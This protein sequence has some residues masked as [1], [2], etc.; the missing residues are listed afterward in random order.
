[1]AQSGGSSPL[2][3]YG[4]GEVVGNTQVPQ[5]LMGSVGVAVTEP[6]GISPLNPASYVSLRKATFETGFAGHFTELSTDGA[7]QDRNDVRVLGMSLGIPW[8]NGRWG[9]AIGMLP[10]TSTGYYVTDKQEL[11]NGDEVTFQYRGTGGLNR[12]FLGL[13]HT[14]WRAKPDSSGR[15]RG[16]LAVGANFNFLFGT[17]EAS[18]NAIYPVGQGYTNLLSYTGLVLRGPTGNFGLHYSNELISLKTMVDRRKARFQREVDAHAEWVRTHPDEQREAPKIGPLPQVPWRYVIGLCGEMGTNLG[19]KRNAL[20]TSYVIS[21][22]VEVIRDTNNVSVGRKG[23]LF[24]PPSFGAGF[25][26]MNERWNISADV[27]GRDWS[28]LR[29]DVDGY[30]LP[31]QLRP[32]MSY[33]AGAAFRPARD[34]DREFLKRLIYRAGIRYTTDY[35]KVRD[36]Q[37]DEL[38]VSGGISIPLSEGNYLARVHLGVVAG[39]RGDAVETGIKERFANFYIGLTLTP[40]LRERW[41]SPFRIE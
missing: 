8:G 1:M 7:T 34:R 41:F 4:L 26:L 28:A 12:A 14:I 40:N 35:L 37:L 3:A 10:V 22:G 31:S 30:S 6:A 36:L 20:E 19:A 23:T 38:A 32:S 15:A 2:S 33:Q 25:Q 24:I 16:Q 17:V 18:S 11:S 39:Q 27:R 9:L 29:L 13:A 5:L 21:S